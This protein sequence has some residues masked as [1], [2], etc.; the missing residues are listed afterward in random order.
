MTH[1]SFKSIFLAVALI[2][3]CNISQSISTNS[4]YKNAPEG[5]YIFLERMFTIEPHL[6]LDDMSRN[7][8]STGIVTSAI[9]LGTRENFNWKDFP[10]N[11]TKAD[12]GKIAVIGASAA[13]IYNFHY[14]KP[15]KE[16]L[17]ADQLVKFVKNWGSY[18]E[19]T[20][21]EFH[22]LFDS[23]AALLEEKGEQIIRDRSLE[24]TKTVEHVLNHHF[25]EHY[26]FMSHCK[27]SSK[28]ASGLLEGLT[29]TVKTLLTFK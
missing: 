17:Y 4:V 2:T 10:T 9:F 22:E 11:V 23:L 18:K 15:K 8:I 5:K 6:S 3:S 21:E 7:L 20:P 27:G 29:N 16:Q 14:L 19:L 12:L 25:D 13:Y 1:K 28:S 26:F 24:V